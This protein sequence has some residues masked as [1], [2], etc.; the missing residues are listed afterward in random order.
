M[1]G[2][3]AFRKGAAGVVQRLLRLPVM[4][5]LLVVQSAQV[6]LIGLAAASATLWAAPPAVT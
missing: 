4:A 5:R 2:G 3:E 1:S 6:V